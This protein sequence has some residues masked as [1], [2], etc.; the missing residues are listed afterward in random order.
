MMQGRGPLLRFDMASY[1]RGSP[2]RKL[3]ARASLARSL[4][5]TYRD[6]GDGEAAMNEWEGASESRHVAVHGKF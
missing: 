5:L 4:M 3:S 6:D 1:I 2:G